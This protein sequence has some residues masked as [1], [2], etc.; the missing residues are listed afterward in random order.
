MAGF[1][2]VST[3]MSFLLHELAINPDV[4]EK[5]YKEIKENEAKNNGIFDYNSIQKMVYMDMVISGS[6]LK[7]AFLR[8][9]YKKRIKHLVCERYLCVFLV[10]YF[11]SSLFLST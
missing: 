6:C 10:I 9:S 8:I 7:K 11:S 4:Q 2:T 1:D 5:L 3:V